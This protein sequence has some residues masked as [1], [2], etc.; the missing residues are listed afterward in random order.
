M[1]AIP[2]TGPVQV[3]GGPTAGQS[4]SVVFA[5]S[6]PIG[7]NI[8]STKLR[9]ASGIYSPASQTFPSSNTSTFPLSKFLGLKF[10]TLV[11]LTT[12]TSWTST[13]TGS[14][15][16]Y[17][18][19]GGGGGGPSSD[20]FRTNPTGAIQAGWM[21][22]GGGAGRVLTT[23]IA[24]TKGTAYVYAIGGGGGGGVSGG[25]TSFTATPPA[26]ALGGGFGGS[27]TL[28]PT[29]IAG[30]PGGSGGGGGI[31]RPGS[32][33]LPWTTSA[34]GTGTSP[35]GTS[36]ATSATTVVPVTGTVGIAGGGGGSA[37][38][39]GTAVPTSNVN[40]GGIGITFPVSGTTIYAGG[41]SGGNQMYPYTPPSGGGNAGRYGATTTGIAGGNATTTGSGGGGGSTLIG[42]NP[43]TTRQIFSGGSG[44]AGIIIISF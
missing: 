8:P 19:G 2:P 11:T 30:Q 9:L 43:L 38:A 15:T 20:R 5:W 29:V 21:G 44:T 41:G 24:V 14:G 22:G 40:T 18:V 12:G 36:G 35:G 27:G 33:P 39:G 3:A 28:T 13:F 32:A 34:G 16:F 4:G 26:V 7:A 23:S 37:T 31:A 6:I 25:T 17:M 42:V 10:T 1:S